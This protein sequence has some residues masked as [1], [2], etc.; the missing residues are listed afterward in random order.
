V[1]PSTC[2]YW[3]DNSFCCFVAAAPYNADDGAPLSFFKYRKHFP[4]AAVSAALR[5]DAPE[6]QVLQGAKKEQLTEASSGDVAAK[7]WGESGTRAQLKSQSR[8][9]R[10]NAENGGVRL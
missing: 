7:A 9:L 1:G 3:S 2:F 4:L 8:Q 10:A 6:S 5:P